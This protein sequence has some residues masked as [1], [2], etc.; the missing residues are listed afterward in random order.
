M[1]IEIDPESFTGEIEKEIRAEMYKPPS[2]KKAIT[3]RPRGKQVHACTECSYT[4]HQRNL[5][6]KHHDA[7]HKNLKPFGCKDCSFT[8]FSNSLL[9][10]HIKAVHRKIKPFR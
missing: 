4:T 7:V 6:R 10:M 3:T 2:K 5:L 9:N 1:E 8:A